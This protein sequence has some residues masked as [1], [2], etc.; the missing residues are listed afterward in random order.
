MSP[1]TAPSEVPSDRPS[2]EPSQAPSLRPSSSP[3]K[4]ISIGTDISNFS[5]GTASSKDQDKSTCTHTFTE[6]DFKLENRLSGTKPPPQI[7]IILSLSIILFVV[8]AAILFVVLKS[9]KT[10]RVSAS[11][12]KHLENERANKYRYFLD[13]P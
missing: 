7:V 4:T 5:G 12:E 1:T 10:Q 6:G 2:I 13:A 9:N 3:M 8:S 11:F